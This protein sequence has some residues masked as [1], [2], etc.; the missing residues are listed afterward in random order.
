ML[1]NSTLYDKK[2]KRSEWG[3]RTRIHGVITIR[4]ACSPLVH[5]SDF[6]WFLEYNSHN[7]LTCVA[8]KG[9]KVGLR[10][11]Y[12]AAFEYFR[13]GIMRF[14]RPIRI[15]HLFPAPGLLIDSSGYEVGRRSHFVIFDCVNLWY[16]IE[17]ESQTGDTTT[18]L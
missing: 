10:N 16:E 9:L 3:T 15:K 2:K 14:E 6:S 17:Y 13:P 12:L 1:K 18:K 4:P 7:N 8:L 5:C 11:V